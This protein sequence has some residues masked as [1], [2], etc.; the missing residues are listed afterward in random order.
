MAAHNELGKQG[1]TLAVAHL[2]Q[3]GYT[4]LHTNWTFQKAEVDI[5]A[6]LGN[7]LAVIEVKPELRPTLVTHKILSLLKK[8]S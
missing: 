7:T 5:L 6:Q 2:L 8:F 1:E 3:K 4:V